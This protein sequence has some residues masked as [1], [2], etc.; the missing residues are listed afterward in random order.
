MVP[1]I[2]STNTILL[3]AAT[4]ATIGSCQFA[5]VMPLP[6]VPLMYTNYRLTLPHIREKRKK[7]LQCAYHICDSVPSADRVFF[8]DCGH[9][10]CRE[11]ADQIREPAIAPLI[12][13]PYCGIDSEIIEMADDIMELDEAAAKKQRKKEKRERRKNDE[14]ASSQNEGSSSQ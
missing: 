1:D 12:V 13:C 10:V 11:Y 9:V 6:R 3:I 14:E 7:S 2:D 8:V 4:T 5:C